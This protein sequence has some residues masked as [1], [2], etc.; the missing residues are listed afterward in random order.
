MVHRVHDRGEYQCQYRS[1]D[2]R[3]CTSRT[4]LQIEHVKPFAMYRSHDE[5]FL[6]LFCAAHNRLAGERVYGREFL[7]RKIER[8]RQVTPSSVA[9]TV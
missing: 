6:K 8:S 1:P 2:G 7:E 9:G 4:G 5:R 3:R